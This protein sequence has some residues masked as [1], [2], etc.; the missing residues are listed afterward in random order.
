MV[1]DFYN[2]KQLLFSCL[3]LFSEFELNKKNLF[4]SDLLKE[5]DSIIS[6]LFFYNNKQFLFRH[7]RLFSEF[8]LNKKNLLCSNLSKEDDFYQAKYIY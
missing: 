1:L 8:E 7:L 6:K 3:C 4:S 5:V 2:S